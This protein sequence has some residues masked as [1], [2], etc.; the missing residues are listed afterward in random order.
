MKE[1]LLL[2]HAK[3]SWADPDQD[4]AD[5]PLNKRG[6]RTAARMA[7]WMAEQGLRPALILCSSARRTRETLDLI[8]DTV[9]TGV[10]L[11]I[12]PELYLADPATLLDRVR[13]LP[14]AIQSVLVIGH[15]PGLQ[16][17]A[18]ELARRAAVDQ[19]GARKKLQQKFPTAAL[20]RFRFAI[21]GWP[22]L[23]AG[24]PANVARLVSYITP[25]DIGEDE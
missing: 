23:A 22:A 3:S 14:D 9:G 13:S 25:A 12:E 24:A 11:R 4:D 10:P 19:P 6:R 1:L 2:R 7:K 20:A 18:L 16:E 17:L 21:D 15:N 5:R 8:A